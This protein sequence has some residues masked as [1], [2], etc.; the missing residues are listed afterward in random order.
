MLF[1]GCLNCRFLLVW[2]GVISLLAFQATSASEDIETGSLCIGLE[3]T[4]HN[5]DF[6]SLLQGD[7]F[8][9]EA[10]SS[11]SESEEDESLNAQVAHCI[12]Y[13]YPSLS[14]PKPGPASFV[15]LKPAPARKDS[16]C[17]Q[18][19][20]VS[21]KKNM[22]KIVV[23][24]C[25][26]MAMVTS[27]RFVARSNFRQMAIPADKVVR[28]MKPQ[29]CIAAPPITTLVKASRVPTTFSKDLCRSQRINMAVNSVLMPK[30][31]Q[32]LEDKTRVYNDLKKDTAMR[33]QQQN[34]KLL[35]L[36]YSNSE[37]QKVLQRNNTQY[38]NLEA[39]LNNSQAPGDAVV[40]L[41]RLCEVLDSKNEAMR[42]NIERSKR[43]NTQNNLQL[44][45]MY[46]LC[47][48]L[49]AVSLFAQ[50]EVIIRSCVCVWSYLNK[51]NLGIKACC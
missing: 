5:V 29:Q 38:E 13:I 48:F 28:Y 18:W 10:D 23:S 50:R 9:D 24:V 41:S 45:H 31:T 25:S 32:M 8:K 30:L 27:Q 14:V 46:V 19:L 34:K 21:L 22:S 1:S 51:T 15:A 33:L 47:L 35:A 3:V 20:A 39:K 12:Q 44:T 7:F 43:V 49:V 37:Q 11:L 16:H 4:H 17:W 36:E 6:S 42:D 40:E 2:V 26:G